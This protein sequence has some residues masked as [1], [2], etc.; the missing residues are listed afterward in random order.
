MTYSIDPVPEGVRARLDVTVPA[1]VADAFADYLLQALP[2]LPPEQ[3][4]IVLRVIQELQEAA[5]QSRLLGK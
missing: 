3:G 1:E 5:A 4:T 2:Q